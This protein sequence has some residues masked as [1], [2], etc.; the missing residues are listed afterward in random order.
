M[1]RFLNV[2]IIQQEL[3]YD[4]DKNLQRL[5]QKIDAIMN[6]YHRPEIVV[7]VEGGI[8]YFSPEKIPGKIT[9]YLCSLAKKYSIYL[10][11][12]SM[13]ELHDDL[14]K[15]YF[16]NSVPII[17]PMGEIISVYRKMA[18]WRPSESRTV[19]GRE[20]VVFDM[21]EKGTK[22]GIMICYD[23]NFPEIAR[24]LTLMGAEV[25]IKI[26]QDPFE[27]AQMNKPIHMTRAH[28]N[29]AYLISTNAVG[30]FENFTLYGNSM[31]VNPEGQI[32]W[33]CGEIETIATVTIDLDNVRKCRE[34]GTKFMDTYLKHIRDF[35]LPMPFANKAKEAPI[36]R[37]LGDSPINKKEYAQKIKEIG[38]YNIGINDKEKKR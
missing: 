21:P 26:T 1:N 28:E 23:I 2:G 29:Q 18:P 7:G 27:F 5:T 24:N 31:V 15:G 20:Y 37:N 4:T 17:N 8:G 25:L 14:E 12:G 22:V 33:E 36:F 9:D 34:Y 16:Y 3:F 19:A 30:N 35:N 38:L 10:I 13:F 11:P 6:G 32:V